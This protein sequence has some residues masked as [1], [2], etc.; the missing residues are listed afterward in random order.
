MLRPYVTSIHGYRD[1]PDPGTVHHGLPSPTLT[2]VI[3][4]DEPLDC[5]WLATPQTHESRWV[6]SAGLHT[7][8]ALIRTHGHQHGIQL[9][10]TPSGARALLGLPAA[11]LAGEIVAAEDLPPALV[12]AALSDRLGALPDWPS[13]FV[14][15]CDLVTGLLA[16]ADEGGGV[17]AE[18][19]EAWRILART[20]GGIR[21]D[22]LAGHLGWGRR[23]LL[24]RFRTEYGVG[25]KEAA[26]LFRFDRARSLADR[27]V[28]LAEVAATCGY[29]DQSHLTREWVAMAGRT[30]RDLRAG[31]YVNPPPVPAHSFKTGGQRLA[32]VGP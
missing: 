16:R 15:L 1:A 22:D 28:P 7:R 21:V 26:R 17:S 14:A 32:T 8:P 13:R 19:D 25:P 24:E 11:A 29:A 12:S 18:L 4:F 9:A 2:L 5:G 20:A 30:P 23:R 31:A 6:T 10:L 27:G 3:A